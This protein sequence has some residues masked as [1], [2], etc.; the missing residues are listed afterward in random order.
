MACTNR[1]WWYKHKNAKNNKIICISHSKH[2][3]GTRQY[4]GMRKNIISYIGLRCIVH[5]NY[6]RKNYACKGAVYENMM[7][8]A[9]LWV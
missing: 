6:G 3:N 2:M 4:T 8:F 1:L 9:F 5:K 7:T